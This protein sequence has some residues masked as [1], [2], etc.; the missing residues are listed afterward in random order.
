[1]QDERS[2]T[3]RKVL[4]SWYL[5]FYGALLTEN[6]R[7]MSRLY[8]EEDFSLTEI[9]EQFSVSR[10]SVY[11]TVTRTEK[12]LLELEKKLGLCKRFER[13]EEVLSKVSKILEGVRA[14]QDTQDQLSSAQ[15]LIR[16]LLEEEEG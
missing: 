14:T 13:T 3:E 11:D 6:Q 1:M 5:S 8:A 7:S 4:F 15:E 10:Q 12:Q 9:A 2:L 16:N